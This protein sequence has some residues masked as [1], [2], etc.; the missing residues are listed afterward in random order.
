[1]IRPSTYVRENNE[2][3]KKNNGMKTYPVGFRI[4]RDVVDKES[5][6]DENSNFVEICGG[7]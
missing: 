7:K 2:C 6:S 5:A 3:T 1:M 4:L